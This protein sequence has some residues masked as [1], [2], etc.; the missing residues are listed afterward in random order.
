MC[1]YL[2]K[3]ALFF[4]LLQLLMHARTSCWMISGMI[5]LEIKNSV[6]DELS[7]AAGKKKKMRIAFGCVHKKISEKIIPSI[8]PFKVEFLQ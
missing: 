6:S 7:A 5:F 2:S 3:T 1:K 8:A 4:I